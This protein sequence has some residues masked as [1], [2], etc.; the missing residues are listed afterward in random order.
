VLL[1]TRAVLD[2]ERASLRFV[3]TGGV[4]L[5]LGGWLSA[6]RWLRMPE[7]PETLAIVPAGVLTAALATAAAAA[8]F[9][10]AMAKSALLA[11]LWRRR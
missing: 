6:V 5:A 10:P 11:P 3:I 1:A 8:L 9:A 2:V 4:A 7:R